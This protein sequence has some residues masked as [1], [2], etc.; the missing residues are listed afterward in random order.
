M[1]I[2]EAREMVKVAASFLTAQEPTARDVRLEQIEQHDDGEFY[3]VL[4]FPDGTPRFSLPMGSNDGRVYKELVV[5]RDQKEV[6]ALRI[7]KK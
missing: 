2:E 5:K 3:I 6:M 4:S 1:Q 7:W